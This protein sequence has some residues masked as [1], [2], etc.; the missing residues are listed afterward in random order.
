MHDCCIIYTSWIWGRLNLFR[1][2]FVSYLHFVENVEKNLDECQEQYYV[3]EQD[4]YTL[5]RKYNVIDLEKFV[6][7]LPFNP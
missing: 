1:A 4:S 5:I 6:K 3:K 7:N 2:E